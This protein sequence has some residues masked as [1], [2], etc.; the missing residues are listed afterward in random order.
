MTSGTAFTARDISGLAGP[1]R[2][3]AVRAGAAIMKVRARGFDVTKKEDRTPVTD[4]DYAAEAEILP[5]L[6]ELTPAVPVL[7]EEAAAAGD[8]P[9]FD[10]EPIWVV[11][12]L[13]GTRD[14]VEGGTEFAVCI[15]LVVD[16]R[17]LFGLIH[18]PAMG[19]TYW[20]AGT[21]SAM[22]AKGGGVGA[23]I[24]A[25]TPPEAGPTVI[26]SR[27]HSKAGRLAQFLKTLEMSGRIM[28]SSALKFGLLAD[29]TA[30]IYPRFGPTCE[31][32]TAAG[33]A[34][35]AA[36]GGSVTTLDGAELGYGKTDF[37]NPGFIA[38]GAQDSAQDGAQA[39]TQD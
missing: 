23:A 12:P 9:R 4:A 32:D 10:K 17:P 29:G 13:D 8:T 21:T 5:A 15:G 20:T 30:D 35:L 25:R 19:L 14:F 18:G 2:A 7:S 24:A 31:W 3:I 33:H 39:G 11:D 1:V 34:I 26:T 6:G 38:R 27:F 28:M 37:L 22:R 36:A 16:R